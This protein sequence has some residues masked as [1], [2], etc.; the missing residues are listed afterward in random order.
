MRIIYTS[1][2]SL[3]SIGTAA[4]A[5]VIPNHE[6]FPLHPKAPSKS[7]VRM[8]SAT[9]TKQYIP[10]Y[11]QAGLAGSNLIAGADGSPTL[12]DVWAYTD[13]SVQ[14]QSIGIANGVAG[15]D[16]S[17]NLNSPVNSPSVDTVLP[18]V[19]NTVRSFRGFANPNNEG[20][21]NAGSAMT[22]VGGS[23]M[24][25]AHNPYQSQGGAAWTQ[26]EA[27][28][29]RMDGP[30]NFGFGLGLFD[31]PEVYGSQPAAISGD[32]FRG[33][34]VPSQ[35][36]VMLYQ[37]PTNKTANLIMPVSSYTATT[38]TLSIALT[39]QELLEAHPGAWIT[40]NSLASGD[41]S[42]KDNTYHI[43]TYTGVIRSVSGDARTV[44]VYGWS[45]PGGSKGT[46]GMTNLETYYFYG[47]STPT[48]FI[49]APTKMF[50]A[51]VYMSY[52]GAKTGGNGRP[53]TSLI[54][55]LEWNEVDMNISNEKRPNSVS[56]H[57]L[58]LT[59]LGNT[60]ALT[61]ESYDLTLAGG[62]PNMLNIWDGCGSMGIN[63]S[64]LNL[65]ASCDLN[66]PAS[67]PSTAQSVEVVNFRSGAQA[68]NNPGIR[69]N[70]DYQIWGQYGNSGN[71]GPANSGAT[72]L[73]YI[74]H[75]GMLIDG[76]LA[77]SSDQTHAGTGGSNLGDIQWNMNG[78]IGGIGLCAY[79][80]NCGV[81]VEGGG[82]SDLDYGAR[83]TGALTL[84]GS[85]LAQDNQGNNTAQ[86]YPQNSGD[87]LLG[88]SVPGG[89]NLLGVNSMYSRRV[90]VGGVG[91]IPSTSTTPTKLSGQGVLS[92]WGEI[93]P[94]LA[95][96][97]YTNIDPTNSGAGYVWRTVPG[98]ASGSAVD[99]RQ[100]LEKLTAQS[101]DFSEPLTA[102]SFDMR[103]SSSLENG[104]ILW[105]KP[106]SISNNLI[107]GWGAIDSYT[108]AL[109]SNIG[110]AVSV[111][112]SGDF[113]S[114][115]GTGSATPGSLTG[116]GVN[117]SGLHPDG[118]GNWSTTTDTAGGG[119][120]REASYSLENLPNS[121]EVEGTQ[122][123]CSDC[124][125][126]KGHTGIPVYWRASEGAWT[127]AMDNP[128]SN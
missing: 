7:I 4:A 20:N 36:A 109:Q 12:N 29:G 17:G 9:A 46:P 18:L 6:R 62:A 101:A 19:D 15:L 87:W 90:S 122:L 92:T 117:V 55:S 22:L 82:Q 5:D 13:S 79:A 8:A 67:S 102:P 48:V 71:L 107:A 111:R 100:Y 96:S 26:S 35:D 16:A 59:P 39:Q 38:V 103:N 113:Q 37:N 119:G 60:S 84:R 99:T 21:W 27:V 106:A 94:G 127:D 63:E 115:S 76:T 11:A 23:S 118:H 65:P 2:F 30:Y 51:N 104:S 53:A 108:M 24:S 66:L 56:M 10:V 75:F 52:D 91:Y 40:T 47:Y 77:T 49:G 116:A 78:Q 28:Y 95:L 126:P 32:D 3:L 85:I 33:G 42:S 58:T 54:H 45:I 69:H 105:I 83:V 93:Q 25:L 57:G 61:R 44:T 120:F 110:A 80:K 128:L 64:T 31:E 88:T 81:V 50:G 70:I 86:L 124:K 72:F 121:N 112:I 114:T 97:E 125:T 73:S 41:Q 14:Q 98:G 89:A 43:N 1:L 68:N 123:W 34:N 74:G